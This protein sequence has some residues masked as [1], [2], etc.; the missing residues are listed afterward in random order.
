[1]AVMA[2]GMLPADIDRSLRT[3]LRQLPVMLRTAGLAATYAYVLA[4]RGSDSSLEQAYQKVADGIRTYL[5]DRALIG[6]V[7]RWDSDRA[8]LDALAQADRAAYQR[9]S[10]EVSA[11][12]GW[13]SRLADARFQEGESRRRAEAALR[14]SAAQA[15]ETEEP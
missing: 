15:E 4:K 6:G 12:A 13:L 9:A 10:A 1:M 5:G 11:L 2:S 3:R 14:E 7:T 8:L